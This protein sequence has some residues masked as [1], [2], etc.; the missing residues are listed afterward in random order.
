MEFSAQ[1]IAE[2]LNGTVEGDK[3]VKVNNI[4]RIEDGKEGTLSFLANPKYTKYIYNT[5]A[6][7]VL[8]NKGFKPE[9]NISATLIRVEDAYQS[10]A[11]LLA[12]YNK[13]KSTKKGVQEFAFVE[14]DVQ[15]GGNIY[16]GQFAYV[17]H[18]C[19]IG[20]NVKI[21]PHVYVGDNVEIQDNTIIFSGVNIYHDSKIGKDCIIH[22]G[23]VIGADG[24]GFAPKSHSDFKKV[25]QIGNVIIE[26]NVEIGSNTSIDRATIGSTIIKRGVK[27]DNL[28]Q[29][30]HNVEI[31]DNT[32]IAAQSGIS[33]STKIGK[34]CMIAGQV[35]MVGHLTIADEVKIGAQSGINQSIKEKGTI[36]QGSPSFNIRAYQKSY[37][38][39][40]RLPDFYKE[41]NAMKNELEKL[42]AQMKGEK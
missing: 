21:Y 19:K 15:L 30:A 18:N 41:F 40:R 14:E 1:Y 36:Q 32:V 3:D 24:F 8:V 38:I 27:L 28:I 12:L 6:S 2:Y 39:F 25:P 33:G 26:D 23:T 11:S 17:G 5:K 42:K 9:K 31:G 35:G 16:I 7:I 10:F 20:D 22:S 4:S 29:V 34:D 37:V 13:F